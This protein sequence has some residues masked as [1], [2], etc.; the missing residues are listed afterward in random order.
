MSSHP[1]LLHIEIIDHLDHDTCQTTKLLALQDLQPRSLR[2]IEK[3]GSTKV[4][5]LILEKNL[6][7]KRSAE[8]NTQIDFNLNGLGSFTVVSDQGTME[9]V[10]KLQHHQINTSNIKLTYQLIIDG[11][12]VTHQTIRY[13]I[14][15]AQA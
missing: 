10:V 5:L 11:S 6:I 4:E 9:G 7:L 1:V 15:G 12:I 13:T 2:Y 14:K 8:W 3:D